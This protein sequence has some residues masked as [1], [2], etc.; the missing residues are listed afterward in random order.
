MTAGKRLKKCAPP[1]QKLSATRKKRQARENNAP[2]SAF[3]FLPSAF[4]LL[5]SAFCL[6]LSA[7]CFLLSAF[8]LLL[9]AFCLLPSGFC[10]LLSAFCFLPSAFCFL[11][12]AHCPLPTDLPAPVFAIILGF[13]G[14]ALANLSLVLER[15]QFTNILLYL[16]N[17]G[18]VVG[19]AVAAARRR[20]H[21][22]SC[23]QTD[24]QH[25]TQPENHADSFHYLAPFQ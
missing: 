5:P 16:V 24:Q 11:L 20:A 19:A 3:C 6:L 14:P 10:L 7:F 25:Q 17:V 2:L 9:S 8:C 15:N 22:G 1:A 21:R 13:F 12:T 4:C 18:A 23:P